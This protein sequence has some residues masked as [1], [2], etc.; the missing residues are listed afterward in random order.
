VSLDIAALQ[1]DVDD[2]GEQLKAA[3][4]RLNQAKI[5]A[6]PIKVGERLRYWT[7]TKDAEVTRLTVRYGRVRAFGRRVLKGGGLHKLES[8]LWGDWRPIVP[9]P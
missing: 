8:E 3:E 5:D 6:H 1:A 9:Q 4:A 7:G 2:L